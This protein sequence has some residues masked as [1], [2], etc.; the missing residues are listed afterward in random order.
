MVRASRDGG[1]RDAGEVLRRGA[2][3][4]RVHH[5][6][7]MLRARFTYLREGTVHVR[8]CTLSTITVRDHASIILP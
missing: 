4:L 3:T 7:V 2:T 8:Y 1:I 5:R 6:F